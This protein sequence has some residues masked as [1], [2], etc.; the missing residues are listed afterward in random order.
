MDAVTGRRGH[1]RGRVGQPGEEETH[2]AEVEDGVGAAEAVGQHAARFGRGQVAVGDDDHE[3]QLL[4]QRQW[5]PRGAALDGGGSDEPA[6]R[7][8]RRVLGVPVVGRRH[9]KGI[10]GAGGGG[11]RGGESG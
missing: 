5:R 3:G 6:E 8:R 10:V 1:E 4:A 11:R 9:G 2:A 7:A